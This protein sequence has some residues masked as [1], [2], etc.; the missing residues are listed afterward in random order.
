MREISWGRAY[1]YAV[2]FIAY[3][4]LWLL[5]GG[6]LAAMGAL[7]IAHGGAPGI[8]VGIVLILVGYVVGGLGTLAT[9]F[10][11]MSRLMVETLREERK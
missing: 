9:F 5:V 3:S 10:K 1:G 11:L 2:R 8:A 6:V 7:A 4:I